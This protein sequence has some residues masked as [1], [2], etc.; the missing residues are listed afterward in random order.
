MDKFEP[1]SGS[2]D[3]DHTKEAVS[4]LVVTRGDGAV[5]LEVTEHALDA[6][7][8]LV[9]RPVMFELLTAV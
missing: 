3:M 2:G 1:V 9:E 5:D 4:K 6:V 7:A 8:L